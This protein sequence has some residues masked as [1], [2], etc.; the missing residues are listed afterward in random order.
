MAVKGYSTFP[1]TP[2]LLESQHKIVL[3]HLP[4]TFWG[5]GSYPSA[6]MQSVYSTAPD[7]WACRPVSYV[8]ENVL[9][10]TLQN[11]SFI[12]WFSFLVTSGPPLFLGRSSHPRYIQRILSSTN[13]I[14]NHCRFNIHERNRVLRHRRWVG[15]FAHTHTHSL[16]LSLSNFNIFSTNTIGSSMVNVKASG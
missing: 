7:D 5:G 16:S 12:I 11:W 6:D 4:S 9:Y 15:T 1:K 13:N 10:T 8:N 3:C 14:I 2:A